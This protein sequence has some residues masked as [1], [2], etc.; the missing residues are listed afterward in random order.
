MTGNFAGV[1][2][3]HFRI[4]CAHCRTGDDN[5]CSGDIGC[6]VAFVNGSAQLRQAIGHRA[7]AQIGARDLHAQVEQDLSDAA[8]ADSADTDEVRVL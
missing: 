1:R 4:G 3:L 2:F 5:R 6:A 8:H 7:A